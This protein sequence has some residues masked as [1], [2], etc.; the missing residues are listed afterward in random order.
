MIEWVNCMGSMQ[1]RGRERQK[2]SC[3]LEISSANTRK[4][5]CRSM[6]GHTHLFSRIVF[7]EQ[8]SLSEQL[9]PHG[10]SRTHQT[11]S[12]CCIPEHFTSRDCL[13]Q[14]LP[15]N[16]TAAHWWGR[17]DTLLCFASTGIKRSP[18]PIQQHID[19]GSFAGR[20]HSQPPTVHIM[21]CRSTT[22]FL[23]NCKQLFVR[24]WV[25]N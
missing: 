13:P 21:S 11:Q 19:L 6:M 1:T 17:G 14:L 22:K 2:L 16:E 23:Q 15:S 18:P 5:Y 8:K 3:P 9:T 10:V 20:K 25:F 7:V 12:H 24:I 4:K